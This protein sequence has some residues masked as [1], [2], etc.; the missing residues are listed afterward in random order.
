MTIDILKQIFLFPFKRVLNIFRKLP[1]RSIKYNLQF[2]FSS[3]QLNCVILKNRESLDLINNWIDETSLSKSW[4]QY[5]IPDYIRD[6]IN[7]KINTDITYSDI[8]LLLSYLNFNRTNYLEIG[9]SVGKNFFQIANGVNKPSKI[10]GIDLEDINPI[11]HEKFQFERQELWETPKESLKKTKSSITYYKY[12]KSEITYLCAD[13]WDIHC[14]EKLSNNKFNIIFSD[15]LHTPQA[16]LF[17]FEQI[18]KNN[19][20]DKKFVIIWDDMESEMKY[21]FYKIIRKYKRH[22]GI[23]ETYL[24]TINGWIGEHERKH[25]VGLIANFNI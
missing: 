6:E 24:L 22:L 12:Q 23:K 21:T 25:Q 18:I 16:I 2:P 4:Y 15:A 5:G 7:R 14:W 13:V 8:I 10:F 17:E 11:L 20:L 3:D 1:P 9:V 19:L